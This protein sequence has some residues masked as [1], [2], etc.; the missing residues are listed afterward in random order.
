MNYSRNGKRKKMINI[1][2]YKKQ[3]ENCKNMQEVN[4]FISRYKEKNETNLDW[5]TSE[6]KLEKDLSEEYTEIVK[7]KNARVF[8][9]CN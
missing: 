8:T 9:P 2:K 1:L 7:A 4:D 5:L 6:C 3:L